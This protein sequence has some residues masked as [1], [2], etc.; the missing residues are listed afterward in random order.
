MHS[1]WL[2]VA[3]QTCVGLA[4]RWIA[5]CTPAGACDLAVMRLSAEQLG[6]ALVPFGYAQCPLRCG[7]ACPQMYCAAS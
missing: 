6:L 3:L 4:V 7:K 1:S 2:E 5:A